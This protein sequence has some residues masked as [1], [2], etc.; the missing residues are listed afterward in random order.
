MLFTFSRGDVRKLLNNKRRRVRL[1]LF[2]T[3]VLI[4]FACAR[5]FGTRRTHLYERTD[6]GVAADM[7]ITDE[8]VMIMSGFKRVRTLAALANHY[9]TMGLFQKIVISWG[10][11]SLF[12]EELERL[13]ER[14]GYGDKIL[15]RLAEDGDLNTRFSPVLLTSEDLWSDC[16]FIAD[17]DIF[18]PQTD[19]YR[20]YLSWVEHQSQLVG[21]FPRGHAQLYQNGPLQYVSAPTF[22]Y[23]IVLTKFM[24]LHRQF[25]DLYFSEPMRDIRSLVT[26]FVNCED[27][28]MNAM[29]S[30][31]TGLPPV[32]M[33]AP[34][35]I[36]FGN[37]DG[38]YLR[39]GHSEQRHECLNRFCD[40]FKGSP[41]ISTR[42][43]TDVFRSDQFL[44]G[45]R[46]AEARMHP[47]SGR[48]EDLGMLL[49]SLGTH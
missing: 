20:M 47:T 28:A 16:V 22:E 4:L 18:V 17:D 21:L 48:I 34:K 2:T 24:V 26:R 14:Y 45:K 6:H 11:S 42:L 13:I 32:F 9:A 10:S 44:K 38:L 31:F 43:S 1:G 33:Q 35:K 27:I 19:V 39:S 7:G 46:G 30:N 3:A 15:L 37:I 5:V 23:S 25:L 49:E 8:C 41:F 40:L 36:D 29:V 12:P